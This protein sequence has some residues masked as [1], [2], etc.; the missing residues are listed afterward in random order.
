[1]NPDGE[2]ESASMFSSRMLNVS[3]IAVDYNIGIRRLEK[4]FLKE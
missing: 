4:P 1:M 2:H 3:H